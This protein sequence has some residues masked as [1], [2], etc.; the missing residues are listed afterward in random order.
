VK[1]EFLLFVHD[2]TA[3]KLKAKMSQEFKLSTEMMGGGEGD[4][5]GDV[6]VYAEMSFD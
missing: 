5:E 4:D 3:I 2:R 6:E 1:E